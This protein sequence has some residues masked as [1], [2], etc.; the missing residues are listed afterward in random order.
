M[1]NTMPEESKAKWLVGLRSGEY[2]QGAGVLFNRENGFYCCLGVLQHCLTGGVEYTETRMPIPQTLPSEEFLQDYGI[3]LEFNSVLNPYVML[4][5]GVQ[6]SL[7]ELNDDKGY[8]FKRIAD[9]IEKNF[10]GY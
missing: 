1:N 7:V 5:N 2:K 10:E 9:I 3:I 8:S 4:G 6:T